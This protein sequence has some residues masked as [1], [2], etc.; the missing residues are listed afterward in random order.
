MN[1]KRVTTT[2]LAPRHPL[3]PSHIVDRNDFILQCCRAKRVLHLGCAD[4]PFTEQLFHSGLLLHH[5]LDNLCAQ[6]AGIDI[7]EKGI[8]FLHRQGFKNLFVGE[9]KELGDIIRDLGWIPEIILLGE[10][11][12]HL[13]SPGPLLR[14]C[15]TEM[16]SR[17][18]LLITVPNAFSIKGLLHIILGRE[19]VNNDHVAYYSYTTMR[20]LLSR[21]GLEL[22]DAKCYNPPPNNLIERALDMVMSPLLWRRPYLCAGLIFC[23]R[24][25]RPRDVYS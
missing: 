8:S 6:L 5:K 15:A 13:D 1:K 4:W 12:E 9:A 11:V 10:I 16:S 2:L 14:E 25:L 19:K 24:P 23:C 7:S 3:P 18:T 17:C 21:F 20:Q 22:V